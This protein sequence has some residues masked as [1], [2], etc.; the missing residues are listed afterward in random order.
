[1]E[2]VVEDDEVYLQNAK[3][4]AIRYLDSG[5]MLEAIFSI[6]KDLEEHP[7]FKVAVEKMTPYAVF[8]IR[9]QDYA[10]VKRFILGFR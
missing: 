8:A 10:A 5:Q 7:S 4:K 6:L 3:D 2:T 9:N 1:V